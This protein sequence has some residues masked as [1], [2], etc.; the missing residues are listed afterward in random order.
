KTME[1]QARTQAQEGRQQEATPEQ[2][3]NGKN[4]AIIAYLTIIGL[5]VAFVMNTDKKNPFG[6]YHIRQV[7][8][9]AVSG[10]ALGIIGM[11]PFLGWLIGIIGGILILVMWISGLINAANGKEKPMPI[12]GKQYAKWFESV[13]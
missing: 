12:M 6:A 11:I 1:E 3:D 8:G 13:G 5:I 9:L 2:I 4:I 7:L 10:L